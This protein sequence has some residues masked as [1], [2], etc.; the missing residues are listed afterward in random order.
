MAVLREIVVDCEHAPSLARFWAAVLDGYDVLPYDDAEV[1]RL[2]AL[3]L[4]PET[5]P[6]VAVGGPGPTLFFQQVPERKTVKNRVHMEVEGADRQAEVDR[7][8]ALGATV[9]A[10]RERWTTMLDP[11]GNEFC[12][13][14]PG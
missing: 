8:L 13:A 9:F 5:D 2:A 4:T 10:V 7:L 6:T 3:G 11:E 14:D 12:V 1:A